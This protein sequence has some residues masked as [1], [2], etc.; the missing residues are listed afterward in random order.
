MV[1]H[2]EVPP[3]V[4]KHREGELDDW[5]LGPEFLIVYQFEIIFL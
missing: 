1:G 5:V 3:H 2:V 4:S